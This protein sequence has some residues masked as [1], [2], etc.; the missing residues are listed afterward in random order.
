MREADN[1]VRGSNVH[2][3]PGENGGAAGLHMVSQGSSQAG[4]AGILGGRLPVGGP[5]AHRRVFS[6][7]K[8][9]THKMPVASYKL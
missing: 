3:T 6:S 4:I 9:S 8:A 7:T 2:L 1:H 5:P